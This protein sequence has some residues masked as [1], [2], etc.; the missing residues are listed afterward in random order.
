LYSSAIIIPI[1]YF[2]VEDKDEKA[3]KT[4]PPPEWP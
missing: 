4:G 3:R 1:I 2:M